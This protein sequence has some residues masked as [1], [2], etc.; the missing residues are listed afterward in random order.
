LSPAFMASFISVVK[1]SRMARLLGFGV[2]GI[3]GGA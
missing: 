2:D 1:R 3:G